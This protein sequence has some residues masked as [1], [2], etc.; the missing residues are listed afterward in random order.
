MGKS[1]E[2]NVKFVSLDRYV[3]TYI[4]DFDTPYPSEDDSEIDHRARK[5]IA[6][7]SEGDIVEVV[8]DYDSD[9]YPIVAARKVTGSA[10]ELVR[11]LTER[12]A[13]LEAILAGLPDV[14]RKASDEVRGDRYEDTKRIHHAVALAIEAHIER[15]GRPKQEPRLLYSSRAN[16]D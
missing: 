13:R 5:K 10:E 7:C 6:D 11:L 15:D 2:T 16:R 4:R 1:I 9:S 8:W 14:I 12:V 3:L